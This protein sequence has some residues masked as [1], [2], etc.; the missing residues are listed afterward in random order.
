[1]V[2]LDMGLVLCVHGDNSEVDDHDGVGHGDG[3]QHHG[4]MENHAEV[5]DHGEV[6]RGDGV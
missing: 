6:G 2:K 5:F 4:Q 1:M 3:F